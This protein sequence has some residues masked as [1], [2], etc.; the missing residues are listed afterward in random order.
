MTDKTA[1]S[2]QDP[3]IVVEIEELGLNEQIGQ[4]YIGGGNYDKYYYR[5]DGYT[6]REHNEN[7]YVEA[8]L[9]R[10]RDGEVWHD[11]RD[12]SVKS[13][14]EKV[15]K[16][17]IRI[18]VPPSEHLRMA[19]NVD[20]ASLNPYSGMVPTNETALV[21]STTKEHVQVL[22]RDVENKKL[23]AEGIRMAI[24]VKAAEIR[25]IVSGMTTMVNY[26]KS[27]I[28]LFELYLGVKEEIVQLTDGLTEPPDTP[29]TFRQLILYWDEEMGDP[30]KIN[31]HRALDTFEEWIVKPE[32]LELILPERKGVVAVQ[33]S[34]QVWRDRS[35]YR[36]NETVNRMTYLL[37][38]N[39]DRLYRIWTG[40]ITNSKLFPGPDELVHTD[41]DMTPKM[42]EDHKLTVYREQ[43]L[44][45]QG[46]MDRTPI[47]QPMVH[48]VTL[49]DPGTY[50]DLVKMVYDADNLIDDGHERF[51]DW[52]K[53]ID[54]GITNGS[55]I[56]V[57]WKIGDRE[58]ILRSRFRR[59]YNEHSVPPLPP[60]GLYTIEEI[61]VVK[62]IYNNKETECPVIYYNPGD[63]VWGSWGEW[64][65]HPRK[66]RLAFRLERDD[67]FIM[68]YDAVSLE[69]IEYFLQSRQD[70]VHYRTMMAFLY[71]VRD[72]LIEEKAYEKT[73]VDLI[74]PE[75][76]CDEDIVWEAIKWWKTKNKWKRPIRKD[77]AK[78]WR[79]I[80]RKLIRESA[81]GGT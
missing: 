25:A 42:Q 17:W 30:R 63:T 13:F 32:N 43:V 61:E 21:A 44:L 71:E 6:V 56:I 14:Q 78:A 38:R 37:C 45:L 33:P 4:C 66:N 35:G 57:F 10:T 2:P 67:P 27:V 46:V 62:S 19:L 81:K 11:E 72:H 49:A 76:G 60:E 18:N 15:T 31:D 68:H 50:G 39:G 58:R 41:G 9:S 24:E 73:L 47:F 52:W 23:I 29:I 77:D 12:I 22:K 8:M 26:L 69:D 74:V 80:R 79:M 55:R 28:G 3:R 64:N 53:R 16:A 7:H 36:V 40:H 54:Q 5:F 48:P 34:R 20:P 70:R 75:L 65:P 51:N 1:L 59:Y